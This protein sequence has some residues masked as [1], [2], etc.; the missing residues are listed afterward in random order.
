MDDY[1]THYPDYIFR[2]QADASWKLEP[3]LTRAIRNIYPDATDKKSLSKLVLNTFKKNIRGRCLINFDSAKDDEVWGLG[4]HY[5]LYTPLLDWTRSP[6]AAVYFALAGESKSGIRSIYALLEQDVDDLYV[7]QPSIADE[8][9]IRIV[10]PL[11]HDNSRL[12]SQ[13]GLFLYVPPTDSVEVR[14]EQL[15]DQSHVTMY[16]FTFPDRIR[17]DA[18]AALNL[19]NINSASLFPD[20]Q[21]SAMQ[22][23]YEFAAERHFEKMRETGWPDA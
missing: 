19:R 5:G 22:S 21:G 18:L 1:F 2:G 17:E 14:V 16:K 23:N 10:E 15:K 11:T 13:R 12:V 7:A 6:Y 20:I 3:T 9:K 4:Q 8:D